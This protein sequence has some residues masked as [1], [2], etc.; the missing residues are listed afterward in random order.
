MVPWRPFRG[1]DGSLHG[2]ASTPAVPRQDE[3]VKNHRPPLLPAGL[4]TLTLAG[5]VV[6]ASTTGKG[7]PLQ[8]ERVVLENAR[9][10][11]LEYTSQPHG[12]VCGV[13]THS[14]PAHLTIVLSPARDRATNQGGKPEET[15]M[16]AGDVYWSEGETHT[17]VNIGGTNSR[18]M[19]VEL[20]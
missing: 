3:P 20:K 9:V 17:D 1:Y 19:V 18:V 6:N 7:K 12:D 8:A 11:V 15:N 5:A 4:T 13:G 16:K 10:R 2:G 14:H